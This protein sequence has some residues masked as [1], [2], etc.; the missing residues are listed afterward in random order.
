MRHYIYTLIFMSP[1][2]H[3]RM[4]S[5]THPMFSFHSKSFKNCLFMHYFLQ[6]FFASLILS[7]RYF[8]FKHVNV[9]C[10]ATCSQSISTD[11]SMVLGLKRYWHQHLGLHPEQQTSCQLNLPV[12]KCSYP[13]AK[14]IKE[15]LG[16][17]EMLKIKQ[18]PL[19][20]F[21]TRYEWRWYY[22]SQ[23]CVF[24][25]DIISKLLDFSLWK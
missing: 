13:A 6:P 25:Y 15:M 19:F 12:S 20:V 7:G 10:S 16:N 17:V 23:Q 1:Y 2:A 24:L 9:I 5:S 11:M 3:Y 14:S 4:L 8:I 22:L 18:L 21:I